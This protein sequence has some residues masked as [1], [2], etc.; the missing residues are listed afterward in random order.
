LGF[1]KEGTPLEVSLVL[2]LAQNIKLTC[3]GELGSHRSDNRLNPERTTQPG[4]Y[5]TENRIQTIRRSAG[6]AEIHGGV[7]ESL[8]ASFTGAFV[9]SALGSTET[10]GLTGPGVTVTV[11]G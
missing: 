9:Q 3:G 1:I 7:K 2:K 11:D 5:R 10:F 6:T 4:N 8:E